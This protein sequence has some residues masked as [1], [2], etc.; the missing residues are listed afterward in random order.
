MVFDLKILFLYNPDRL[1][2]NNIVTLSNA[3]DQEGNPVQNPKQ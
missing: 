3:L 1:Y 2:T